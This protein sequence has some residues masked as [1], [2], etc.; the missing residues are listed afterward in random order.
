MQARDAALHRG[1]HRAPIEADAVSLGRV[2]E[3]RDKLVD[4]VRPAQLLLESGVG[5]HLGTEQLKPIVQ[6]QDPLDKLVRRNR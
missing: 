2:D 6:L 5:P 4:V 3:Q 1:S